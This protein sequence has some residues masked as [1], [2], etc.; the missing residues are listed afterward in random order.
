MLELFKTIVDYIILGIQH[1]L[2][3]IRA[4]PSFL[5]FALNLINKFVPQFMLPFIIL[6]ITCLVFIKVKRLIL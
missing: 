1:I 4:I 3:L 5:A 2:E 6:G